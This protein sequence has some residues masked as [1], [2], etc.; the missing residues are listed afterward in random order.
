MGLGS[1]SSF[2]VLL[3]DKKKKKD[4]DKEK[5]KDK[6]DKKVCDLSEYPLP[7]P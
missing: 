4:K 2:A 3:D 5:D 1:Q 6:K 7:S